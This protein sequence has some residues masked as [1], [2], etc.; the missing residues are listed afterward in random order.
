MQQDN[1]KI[2]ARLRDDI[3]DVKVL[4]RHPMETGRREDPASGE[5][6]PRHFIQE[7]LCEHNGKIAM[8][9]DWSWGISADPYLA[10]KV[11]NAQVGDTISVRWT[12]DQGQTAT[13]STE[14]S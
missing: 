2:R 6:I 13:L 8:S 9:L 10:F 5:L 3:A 4:M 7:V 11:K 14:I 12:D 1:G